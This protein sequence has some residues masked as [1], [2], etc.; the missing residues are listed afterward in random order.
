MK[1]YKLKYL[2]NELA[3]KFYG[4]P[5]NDF[6]K[7]LTDSRKT[8]IFNESLF[9][10]IDGAQHDAHRFI[11][12][13]Y[14]K[15]VRSFIISK[16]LDYKKFPE[17]S[18]LK[19]ENSIEALQKLALYKRKEF[20]KPILAITGSN[21]KTIVKEWLYHILAPFYNVSKSPKSYNSQIGVALS[22]W[23]I[24]E[25]SDLAIIEAGISQPGEMG[26]LE[27]I[28]QPNIGILTNIGA[29]HQS[30]FKDENHKTQEKIKLFSNCKY[31]VCNKEFQSKIDFKGEIISWSQDGKNANIY[32]SEVRINKD[33]TE[34]KL[35]YNNQ[36]YN[37]KI[38]F[39]DN[40]SIEN[41]ISCFGFLICFIDNLSED[42]L[43]RFET[44]PGVKMRLETLEAVNNSIL[45]N[46]SY[47]SDINSLEI[48]LDYL[49]QKKGNNSSVL[50][51]S[52]ILQN[53]SNSKRFYSDLS[54][55]IKEKQVDKF[56][57][58]GD[59]LIQNQNQ[60]MENSVFFTSTKDFLDNL[61]FSDFNSSAILLKGARNFKFEDISK[62]L[63]AKS[64]ESYLETNMNMM[65]E[66]LLYFRSILKPKTKIMAMVKAFSYGSG[67]REISVFLQHNK[68]DYLAVAYTD[69]GVELRNNGI[70]T[71]IMVMNPSAKDFSKMIAYNLEPEIYSINL[72]K[73]LDK[74]IKVAKLDKFPIHLKLNTG[75]NR[76][77]I[78]K[79]E[80]DELCN[81][82]NQTKSI[83]LK[84]VFSHLSGSDN[85][86]LDYFT[87]QQI[88]LFDESY[89]LIVNQTKLKPIRH[90]LNSAG[91]IRFTNNQ[92]EMVR[93]G[94][95]LYGLMP[96]ITD[97]IHQVSVFKSIISQ[98]NDVK[99]SET[100]GYNRSGILNKDSRIA[101]IPVG[102]ADGIDRR[103]G[104]GNWSFT[105]NGH[106][107]PTIGNICMD[108]CMVDISNIDANEK[109]EVIVFG[110]ENNI[111]QMAEVL[112]TIPYEVITGI[113]QRVK[114]IYTEE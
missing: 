26:K 23:M 103:L 7:I 32:N 108:M 49:N 5:K 73:Q 41:A 64:H 109:D 84:S 82:I 43:Q 46:D 78:T 55:L 57:G 100:I 107:A 94:I 88:E 75:M 38:P 91:I 9:I 48:A 62:R 15:G 110:P 51:L 44:L 67:Y 69:E 1:K 59:A 86:E 90:I 60:F 98:I 6:C 13:L 18:F 79:D 77:G 105:I 39:I 21:G 99:A 80:I 19:V 10:S 36:A 27:K 37:I 53:S 4:N 76:L 106:K 54:K 112:E 42:I 104:N 24:D 33:N 97:K 34:I 71:K 66:N 8:V 52:D 3:A 89:D 47:N 65:R 50:I 28:I 85:K 25:N 95:G 74:E 70:Y 72:L 17:A 12:E 11:P 68:I 40:G 2:E 101:T 29:A 63:Q 56:I 92:Y 22:L 102:Y 16:D 35:E 87:K 83:E 61:S 30:N 113:S 96:E 31:L 14:Q 58:I 111:N 81:I 93:L 20:K 45:I 114:R